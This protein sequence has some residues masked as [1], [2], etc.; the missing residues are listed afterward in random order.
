MNILERIEKRRVQKRE[1]QRRYRQSP[2]GKAAFKEQYQQRKSLGICVR[3]GKED[4]ERDRVLCWRCRMDDRDRR[5]GVVVPGQDSEGMKR[6]REFNRQQMIAYH[7]SLG[8]KVKAK[9]G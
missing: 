1:A 9:H 4:A 2:Q 8:H 5:V 3:C 7:L 6:K